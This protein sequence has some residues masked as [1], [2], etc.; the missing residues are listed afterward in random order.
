MKADTKLLRLVL[1]SPWSLLIFLVIPA[2]VILSVKFHIIL[3]VANPTKIL[4]VNNICFAILVASRVLWYISR[5]AKPIRYGSGNGR[6]QSVLSIFIPPAEA[7]RVLHKV[8]FVFT[9]DGAYGEKRDFGYL[10]TVFFY[11]GLTLLLSVGTWDNLQ[12]FSGT[13][14]DGMGSA[15]KLSRIESYRR[16]NKGYLSANLDALPQMIITRQVFPDSNLP[17]G[18]T[19]IALILENGKEQKKILVPGHPFSYGNFDIAMTKFVFEPH[20]VIKSL[21]GS[22]LFDELVKLDPLVQKRG[23][24][25]FYGLF[26]GYGI[27]GGIYYQPERSS[28][29][30]VVSR[31]EKKVV[32]DLV[33][34]VDQ[35]VTQGDYIISCAKMGQWSEI[36][37]V[38]RRHK[39]LLLLGGAIAFIGLLLR[40]T[41]RPQ[42]VWLKEAP[43]GCLVRVVGKETKKLLKRS[44]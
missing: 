3:P 21:N 44:V 28:L 24:Y 23:V 30:L 17:K 40:I 35:Q 25:S 6:P 8:G 33:F 10:G 2:L 19:E 5:V 15:T 20:V 34:Q 26:Q 12:Q 13:L 7:Q 32:S 29:M 9:V 41:I 14:L 39:G 43:E 22:V 27:G 4:T 1:A 16:V 37:V 31:E 36:H 11:I 38:H 42:R 18:A